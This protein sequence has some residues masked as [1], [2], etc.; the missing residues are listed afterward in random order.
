MKQYLSFFVGAE[1]YGLEIIEAR[2]ILQYPTVTAVPSMSCS[3]RGVINLRGTAVP[4]VDLGQVFGTGAQQITRP[5]CLV[6]VGNDSPGR[7]TSPVGL[8]GHRGHQGFGLHA[9]KIEAAPGLGP[10]RRP[11]F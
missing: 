9:G 6:V 8:V 5:T 2:E 1:Q 11:K 7:P 3:I 10:R 4:V